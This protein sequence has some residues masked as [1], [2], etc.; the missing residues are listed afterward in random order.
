[1]ILSRRKAKIIPRPNHEGELSFS[2]LNIYGR[3]KKEIE[4]L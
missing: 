3:K 4:L 1:M 2:Y